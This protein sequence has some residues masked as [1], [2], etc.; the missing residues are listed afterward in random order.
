[1][2]EL[3]RQD[4]DT[5]L[6]I[7]KDLT[8]T[9][10]LRA[11]EGGGYRDAGSTERHLR[12]RSRGPAQGEAAFMLLLL[13]LALGG[14]VGWLLMDPDPLL[15]VLAVLPLALVYAGVAFAL[16][17]QRVVVDARGVRT[18]FGPLPLLPSRSFPIEDIH[19]ISGHSTKTL[20]Q[21][22]DS[23]THYRKGFAVTLRDTAGGEARLCSPRTH[24]IARTIANHIDFTL[25]REVSL[26]P[27]EGLEE[28]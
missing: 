3:F 10:R 13:G 7:S 8:V 12:L 14:F 26:L 2:V 23:T 17:T 6:E 9:Y 15:Y 18:S 19:A 5:I 20:V 27:W 21:N 24:D 16:N 25:G 28:S 11:A 22:D 4:E 1:M